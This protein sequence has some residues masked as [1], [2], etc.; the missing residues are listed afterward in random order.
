[1]AGG[2]G[3]RIPLP[4]YSTVGLCKK[5]RRFFFFAAKYNNTPNKI[6]SK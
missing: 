4:L 1:M 5:V 6:K 3:V 2:H